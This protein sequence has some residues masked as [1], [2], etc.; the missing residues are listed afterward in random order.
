MKPGTVKE[1]LLNNILTLLAM[2]PNIVV[3]IAT[4][5]GRILGVLTWEVFFLLLIIV[6]TYAVIGI[7]AI[8]NRI[9]YKSYYYP[10]KKIRT[11]YNYI[12][13]EKK[14]TYRRDSSDTLHYCRT[15][16]IHCCSNQ[17][18]H[19]QDKYIWTGIQP[20]DLKVLPAQGVA[21]IKEKTRIG[22]WRYFDIVL[23]NHMGRGRGAGN[24]L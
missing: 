1:W 21:K 17:L 11:I 13:L 15:M 16:K 4:I 5:A 19:A 3:F 22:I 20:P 14:I 24:I 7:K 8:W 12:V 2:I 18:D 10:W 6:I 9:S 23:N